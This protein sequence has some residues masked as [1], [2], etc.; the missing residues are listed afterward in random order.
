MRQILKQRAISTA[1]I[2]VEL[3][4]KNQDTSTATLDEHGSTFISDSSE[5]KI[6]EKVTPMEIDSFTTNYQLITEQRQNLFQDNFFPN[7]QREHTY[8]FVYIRNMYKQKIYAYTHINFSRG[9]RE[10]KTHPNQK[11]PFSS[12][13][14]QVQSHKTKT[15]KLKR[16][17][18]V[19]LL[20]PLSCTTSAHLLHQV[21]L[22]RLM[23]CDLLQTG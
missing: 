19:P 20:H 6:L 13:T 22:Q 5:T 9:R 2:Q 23:F 8:M 4:P 15:T 14:L 21:K 3:L 12:R 18:S 1:T 11:T 17:I 10:K 16:P 7:L